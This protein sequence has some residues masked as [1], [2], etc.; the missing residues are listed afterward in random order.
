MRSYY[1]DCKSVRRSVKSNA[2][3]IALCSSPPSVPLLFLLGAS[4]G[5]QSCVQAYRKVTWTLTMTN[6]PM[7]KKNFTHV[8]V[9]VFTH[10]EFFFT[11]DFL[12]I[13]TNFSHG[14]I[15]HVVT[16]SHVKS[17]GIT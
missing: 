16:Q 17:K 11:C 14:F 5:I 6:N 9:R 2:G 10:A 4:S 12:T 13:Y 1:R 8:A 7:R 15:Y 3:N